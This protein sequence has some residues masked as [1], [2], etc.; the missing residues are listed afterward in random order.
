MTA[1]PGSDL[2]DL[3]V[4]PNPANEFIRY[5]IPEGI[6]DNSLSIRI[7]DI[8]GKL[9]ASSSLHENE[10]YIGDLPQGIYLL[11]FI[12]STQVFKT[13]KIIIRR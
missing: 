10:I 13:Q 12:S 3:R 7:Y 4:W 9:V 1:K 5:E 8:T 2:S 6:D 11:S